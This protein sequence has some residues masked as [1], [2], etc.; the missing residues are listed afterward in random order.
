LFFYLGVIICVLRLKRVESGFALIWL[1]VG[2][3][4]AF[5]SIPA[6]SFSHTIAALPV[7]YVLAALG[8]VEIVD[9]VVSRHGN[10]KLALSTYLLVSLFVVGLGAWLTLRDYF[11][12]WANE[13]IVRFQYHAPTREVAKWLNQHS[14]IA[15]VAI[16]TNPYQLVL[17]P[18]ALDLDL[19]R[20]DVRARWFSP[21]TALLLPLSGAVI[22]SP[23]ESPGEDVDPWIGTLVDQATLQALDD[24][25]DGLRVYLINTQG[26]RPTGDEQIPIFG[27]TLGL[28]GGGPLSVAAHPGDQVSVQTIWRAFKSADTPALKSFVHVLNEQNQLVAGDDRFEVNAASLQPGDYIAQHS[29]V[30][31]PPDLAPG[32]YR[33]EVGLYH[34]DTGQ[35]LVLPDGRD[36]A[37]INPLEVVA[38]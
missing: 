34:A 5:V 32:Q 33:I 12:T 8:V 37:F 18:L 13:Y 9:K 7:V 19:K 17:D 22:F 20:N 28:L 36:Q 10:K 21:A 11:G 3:A 4:P 25:P 6:A 29:S 24:V 15:D 27:G 2:I 26:W 35:R 30:A 31:L 1:I 38:P 14:E 16:G 23:M